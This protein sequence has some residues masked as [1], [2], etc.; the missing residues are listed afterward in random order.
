MHIPQGDLKSTSPKLQ[1]KR[2]IA[3]NPFLN[4]KLK[5]VLETYTQNVVYLVLL[6]TYI[7]EHI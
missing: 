3:S 5:I 6:R 1:G 4:D 2:K 7:H